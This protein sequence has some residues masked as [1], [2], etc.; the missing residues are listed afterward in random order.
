MSSSWQRMSSTCSRRAVDPSAGT[1]TM[2]A[3]T[4]TLDA[5]NVDH[6]RPDRRATARCCSKSPD[7]A[8]AHLRPQYGRSA[9]A[10]HYGVQRICGR[11]VDPECE[12]G[13][14]AADHL[15][16]ACCARETRLAILGILLAS[17][18]VSSSIFSNGI[19]LFGGGHHPVRP[20]AGTS[21][22]EFQSELIG[23][24]RT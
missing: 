5:F 13:A 6:P 19:A 24:A 10:D 16:G 15:I 21:L 14:G 12:S 3:P 1:L 22:G 23:L 17:G 2:R 7:P 18:Q 8:C 11:A 20:F 9:S 4:T